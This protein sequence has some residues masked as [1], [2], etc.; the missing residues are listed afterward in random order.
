MFYFTV[1]VK[2]ND[3]FYFILFIIIIFFYLIKFEFEK[4]ISAFFNQ[5]SY[6]VWGKAE[7]FIG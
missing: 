7:K 1:D 6:D 3:L 2:N 4:K 5:Y